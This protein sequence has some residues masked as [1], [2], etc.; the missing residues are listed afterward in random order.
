LGRTLDGE[1]QFVFVTGEAG[2]G[3]TTFIE[4]A[5]ERLPAADVGILR[6]C[7][8][9]LFGTNEA[10]QPL[11]DAL[12]DGGRGPDRPLLARLLRHHAPTWLAQMPELLDVDARATFHNDVFGA[13]RERMMR[14]FGE[15][16]EALV[17]SRPYIIVIE[18]L[19]WSDFAT[20]DVLNR[21]AR[22]EGRAPVVVLV[23]YRP[24]DVM[25]EGH[26]LAK[27]H[28]E[29]QIHQFCTTLALD[30]LAQEDVARYLDLRFADPGLTSGLTTQVFE[31]SG[32]QP[33]FVVSLI[34]ELISRR[35]IARVDGAWRLSATEATIRSA[36]PRD[37]K[38]LL[39]HQIGHLGQ[40][41][42]RLLAF[43]SAAGAEFAA[44]TVAGAADGDILEV[45]QELED[46][47][48]AGHIIAG[49]GASEWPDGTY[50]GYYAFQHALYQEVLYEGLAPARRV[51]THR[52]LGETLERG[53]GARASDI[54]PV[55]ARHFSEGRDFPKAIKY[56]DQ[57]AANASKRLAN[58]EAVRYLTQALAFVDRLPAETQLRPRIG[59]L[60][61]RSSALRSVGDLT[62]SLD[63][64]N[65]MI[66][67]AAKAG[68][69][70][71]E[72]NGLL[73]VSRF[74]L[75]AD[76]SQCLRATERALELSDALDNEMFKALVRGSSASLN[77]YLRGWR[78]EDADLCRQSLQLTDGA[79]DHGTLIRRYGIEGI[80]K[81][82]TSDYAEVC[83]AATKG[84][85]M[86]RAA[87]DVFIF[88]LFN[89]LEATALLHLGE[90]R[91]L[92]SETLAALTLAEKNA[93]HP[94]RLL[95]QLTLAWLHA[96][97]LDFDGA[98]TI[99]EAVSEPVFTDNPFAFY[100]RRAV[101]AKSYVGAGRLPEA[102]PHI[103]AIQRHLEADGGDLDFTIYT[104]FYHCL[105]EYYVGIG[106]LPHARAAADRLHAYTSGA[107]DRNHLAL[108]YGARAKIAMAEENFQEAGRHLDQAFDTLGTA[109]F[110]L[111]AVRIHLLAAEF[112]WRTGDVASAARQRNNYEAVVL[113][114]A[115]N[116]DAGDAM[117][118]SLTD[119]LARSSFV[120]A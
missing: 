101:L 115:G 25:T 116:F 44:A 30:R 82:A 20:L 61:H 111:A 102:L 31:R 9:E 22:G 118:V 70:Q 87:G 91:A 94:A 66:S 5:L 14:E 32:G 89:V 81:C 68:D 95:C 65:C 112:Y 47:A 27:I 76:R 4:A 21:L 73:A 104:Q 29:L 35:M 53:Y 75:H 113:R 38:Q 3:K 100:F 57:A 37:L 62:G 97:A 69:V 19:H 24:S 36:I 56:L 109:Y 58:G 67:E 85:A 48:R 88:V 17:A 63:D 42:Q 64:L 77:L 23:T 50:S 105:S 78:D 2:I 107:P 12:K 99:C 110:P 10:F 55:L 83:V 18:D 26:P 79:K 40:S 6:G 86:S 15:F 46:L 96:E 90:W 34:D 98:R 103:N 16:V 54:A 84:K 45:E 1:R 8:T 39:L 43:A 51:R 93:N 117:M 33:L 119:G 41:S 72:V 13:T 120:A 49:S 71:V 108:A 92:R 7:C 59:V 52:Q 28:R 114:L 11:I 106:D 60:R 80:L 74:C